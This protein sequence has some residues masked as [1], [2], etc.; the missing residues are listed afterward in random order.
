MKKRSKKQPFK[1]MDRGQIERVELKKSII[2]N[3]NII[4]VAIIE[5][6]HINFGLDKK[7][8]S[9][10]KKRRTNFTVS[11]IEKFLMLLDQE[12]IFAFGYKGRVSQFSVRVDCPVRGRFFGKEFIMIFD[13]NY[14]KANE[15]HT[16]TLFPGW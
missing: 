8:G 13:T 2:F 16:I 9:L 6:D 3:S 7:T 4:T 15:I 5:I 1:K 14:D 10:N 11:D 12:Q